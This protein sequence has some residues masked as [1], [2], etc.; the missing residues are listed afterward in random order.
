MNAAHGTRS[1]AYASTFAHDY[2]AA[3]LPRIESLIGAD[4]GIFALAFDAFL[5]GLAVHLGA[6][7]GEEVSFHV[8]LDYL[9]DAI[10]FS[11]PAR[12]DLRAKNRLDL[13]MNSWRDNVDRI[14]NGNDFS[15]PQD[16]DSVSYKQLEDQAR[17]TYRE[18]DADR[19]RF[20]TEAADQEDD[21]E[22]NR[23]E[24]VAKSL[25]ELSKTEDGNVK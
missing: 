14:L 9:W 15:L 21:D 5:E 25:R 2:A 3:Q 7:A 12:R 19:K 17:E 23:L 11:G 10:G 4:P 1:F 22:L 8:N 6:P 18:F 16:K 13:T 24:D 20:E